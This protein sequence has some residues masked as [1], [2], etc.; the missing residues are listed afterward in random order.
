[1]N[2]SFE[3]SLVQIKW[4]FL[5][6][7]EIFFHFNNVWWLKWLWCQLAVSAHQLQ[8]SSLTNN[9]QQFAYGIPYF[10]ANK[11]H[12]NFFKGKRGTEGERERAKLEKIH[13]SH[14]LHVLF[15]NLLLMRQTPTLQH[16][17]PRITWLFNEMT[18]KNWIE[19][20][21][22]SEWNRWMC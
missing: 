21:A 7:W 8:L 13:C 3:L 22:D 1:M 5:A 20:R 12:F 15:A 9:W 18:N 14:R 16:L 19:C 11:V 6:I 4:I 10:I 2:D 17:I